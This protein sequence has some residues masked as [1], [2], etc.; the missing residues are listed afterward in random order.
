MTR[1]QPSP[2]AETLDSCRARIQAMYQRS[3]RVRLNIALTHTKVVQDAQATIAGV[4]RHCFC[5]EEYTTGT[6]QC[7]TFTYADVLTKRVELHP[8]N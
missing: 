7:H 2:S 3:P 6:R 5:V 1:T 8:D 4:Y